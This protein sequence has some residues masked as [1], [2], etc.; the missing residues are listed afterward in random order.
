MQ[1]G[2]SRRNILLIVLVTVAA[3]ALIRCATSA[4]D[5]PMAPQYEPAA[6][7]KPFG[8]IG[9]EVRPFEP[10]REAELFA[11]EGR[12]CLTHKDDSD[13][14]FSVYR[15]HEDDPIF[16]E[17][18]LRLT[19]RCGEEIDGKVFHDPKKTRYSTYTWVYEW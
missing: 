19:C 7:L 5:A 10:G 8:I 6:S 16:F 9:K 11:Y 15:F 17:K 2:E 1:A 18:G 12:G 4:Q 14:S 13:H 3:T